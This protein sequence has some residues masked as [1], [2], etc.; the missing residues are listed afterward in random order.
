MLIAAEYIFYWFWDI[1]N[2]GWGIQEYGLHFFFK[3]VL[4]FV[5]LS[6]LFH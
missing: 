1:K 3:R 5:C 2:S 4:V 6:L